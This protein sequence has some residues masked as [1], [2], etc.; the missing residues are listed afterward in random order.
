MSREIIKLNSFIT[1]SISKNSVITKSFNRF[2]IIT[3]FRFFV[4]RIV[5]VFRFMSEVG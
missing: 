4:S 2:S 3:L 1:V 5:K